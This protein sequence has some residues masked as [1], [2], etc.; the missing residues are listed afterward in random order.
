[1]DIDCIILTKTADDTL[2]NLTRQTIDTLIL[3]ESSHK[4]NIKLIE[5]NYSSPYKYEYP[6][7]EVIQPIE[8]FNYNRF[9]NFGL[10][11][12]KSDWII[13]SNNDVIYTSNWLNNLLVEYDKDNELLS[14]C[15]YEPNWHSGYYPIAKEIN[16]GYDAKT[17]VTGWCILINKKVFDIIGKFDEQFAFWYQDDDYG[18][19]LKKYGIKHAMIKSSIVYHLHSRSHHLLQQ[20]EPNSMTWRQKSVFDAKWNNKNN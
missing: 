18:L 11:K 10:N 5:S 7:V 8:T 17:F 12:C 9:L 20:H 2:Y 19:T 15:P 4:F 14:M 3:S 6:N 16:Y 1:M 13:I